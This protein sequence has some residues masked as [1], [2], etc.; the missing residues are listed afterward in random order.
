[1]DIFKPRPTAPAAAAHNGNGNGNGIGHG[2]GSGNGADTHRVPASAS[3]AAGDGGRSHEDGDITARVRAAL[4]ALPDHIALRVGVDTHDG[5]VTLTRS[6]ETRMQTEVAIAIAAQMAGVR[7]VNDHLVATR[8][9]LPPKS[10]PRTIRIGG[11]GR[12]DDARHE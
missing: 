4:S 10:D 6:V 5:V 7:Y 8:Q 2:N 12:D 11:P 9:P 1:M 3:H